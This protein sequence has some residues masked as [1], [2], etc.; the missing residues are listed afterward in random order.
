VRPPS[1]SGRLCFE[2]SDPTVYRWNSQNVVGRWYDRHKTKVEDILGDTIVVLVTKSALLKY[3][4]AEAAERARIRAEEA[5]RR[6]REEARLERI[7]KRR[8]FLFKKA[9]QY[10]QLRRLTVF[11]NFL[12]TKVSVNG[13]GPVDRI[14]RVLDDLIVDKDKQFDRE[15]LNGEITRLELFAEGDPN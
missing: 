7:E 6:R 14:A 9:D 10:I 1:A 12:R 8:E 5:E 11:G 15:T 13:T 4:R 2:L 3:R